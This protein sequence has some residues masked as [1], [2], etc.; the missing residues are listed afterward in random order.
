M[1]GL[2]LVV[3]IDHDFALDFS[4]PSA[5]IVNS[6]YLALPTEGC[7]CSC[8]L[9]SSIYMYLLVFPL[10]F[11]LFFLSLFLVKRFDPLFPLSSLIDI[12]EFLQSSSM[13]SQVSSTS[14]CLSPTL[15]LATFVICL[16]RRPCSMM[17][18]CRTS[19]ALPFFFLWCLS[20]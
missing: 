12:S 18:L 2:N 19:L 11:L 10:S 16:S 14:L 7:F 9:A 5:P 4:L 20:R 17:Y 3:P 15:Y 8:S 6:A 1:R 13:C